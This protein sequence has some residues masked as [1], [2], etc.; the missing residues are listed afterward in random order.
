MRLSQWYEIQSEGK[1]SGQLR[2]GW[3]IKW[4]RQYFTHY[5]EWSFRFRA[6][7]T[8][9]QKASIDEGFIT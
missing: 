8:N 9:T 3:K 2:Y 1:R 5:F 7:I 6:I 4:Y